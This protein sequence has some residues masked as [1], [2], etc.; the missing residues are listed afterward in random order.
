MTQS[1]YIHQI[2]LV[3]NENEQRQAWL[4]VH[5]LTDGPEPQC[6]A[7]SFPS[8]DTLMIAVYE[9]GAGQLEEV[10]FTELSHRTMPVTP[11]I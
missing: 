11:M 8:L 5:R 6:P 4:H 2:Q 10:P 1:E 9:P 7:A 3:T